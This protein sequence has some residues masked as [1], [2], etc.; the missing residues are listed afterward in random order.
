MTSHF[1]H[2]AWWLILL[3]SIVSCYG[4]D[5]R[6][7][8]VPEDMS[9]KEGQNLLS[10]IEARLPLSLSKINL[11][12]NH[13][14]SPLDKAV[15]DSVQVVIHE[16]YSETGYPASSR[17]YSD[18][19]INT[20]RLKDSLH[21]VYLVLLKHFPTGVVNG[22]ILFFDNQKKNLT[23]PIDFNLHAS[24]ELTDGSLIPSNLNKDSDPDIEPTDFDKDGVND[25]KFRRLVH[26]GTYTATQTTIISIRNSSI[27]T[28]YF[29]EQAMGALSEKKLCL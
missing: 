10:C 1:N 11:K 3:F 25:F 19:Y 4:R 17:I 15:A 7:P 9:K 14:S 5:E 12:D 18:L 13:N 6:N 2:S 26:N 23:H 29:C 22:K 21:T 28:V 8:D 16:Y 27:D 24:Y 20:I